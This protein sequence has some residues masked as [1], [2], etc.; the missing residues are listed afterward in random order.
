MENSDRMKTGRNVKKSTQ[1][2]DPTIYD[3]LAAQQ[4]KL[5]SITQLNDATKNTFVDSSNIEFWSG[6]ITVARALKE[7]RTLGASTPIPEASGI[8]TASV[9]DGAIHQVKPTSPEVW[10][11]VSV[12]SGATTLT[13]TDGASSTLVPVDSNGNLYSPLIIPPTLYLTFDNASGSA[14]TVA[15]A[16]HKLSL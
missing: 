15:A 14:V 9:G 13:L 2:D 16:Y 8:D 6:V 4:Q 3:M 10:Q 11:I 1:K 12:F 5:T 7:S